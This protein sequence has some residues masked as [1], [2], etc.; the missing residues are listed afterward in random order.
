MP[1]PNQKLS[2]NFSL[3]EMLHS[4]TAT[5]LGFSEQFE[6][7]PQIIENL[8]QLCINVLQPLRDNLG[9]SFQVSSGY[10]CLRTNSAIKGAKKSQH[11]LGQAADIQDLDKGNAFLFKKLKEL[12]L[13]FDQVIDEFG[14]AWVHVSHKP[15]GS[16]RGEILKATKDKN[17]KTVFERVE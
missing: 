13:P 10:R 2:K 15:N 11:L 8:R 7:S 17:N 9:H 12:N 5:R 16:Q 4:Q 1:V 3:S 14:L 6:P